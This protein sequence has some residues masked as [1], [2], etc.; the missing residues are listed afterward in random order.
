MELAGKLNPP[1]VHATRG[2]EFIQYDNPFDVAMTGRLGFCSGYYA[3][4]NCDVLL[5]IE[6]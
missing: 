3:M 5:M 1:I 2:R 6:S 4:M